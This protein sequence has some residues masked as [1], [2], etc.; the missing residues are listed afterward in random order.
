MKFAVPLIWFAVAAG[1]YVYN[2]GD[3]GQVVM[4]GMNFL[5]GEDPVARG[6]ATVALAVALG[7][8]T[9]ISPVASLFQKKDDSA[10][11]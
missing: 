9:G 11:E 2:Q 4:W 10:D 1:V 6:N 5:V 8:F 3:Q 7:V